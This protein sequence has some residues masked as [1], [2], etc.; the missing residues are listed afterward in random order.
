M[1]VCSQLNSRVEEFKK[2]IESSYSIN[3]TSS[4]TT[5]TKTTTTT[6]SIPGSP[7][8]SKNTC[9]YLKEFK[10]KIM[11]DIEKG[12]QEN[13]ALRTNNSKLKQKIECLRRSSSTSMNIQFIPIKD[14]ISRIKQQIQ[15]QKEHQTNIKTE[16]V[17]YQTMHLKMIEYIMPLTIDC[18]EVDHSVHHNHQLDYFINFMSLRIPL[19]SSPMSVSLESIKNIQTSESNVSACLGYSVLVLK[20]ISFILNLTLPY[21]LVYQG[22]T[23]YIIHQGRKYKLYIDKNNNQHNQQYDFDTSLKMLNKNIMFLCDK[24]NLE[25]PNGKQEASK[26][27]FYNLMW[28]IKSP[29]QYFSSVP[30]KVPALEQ[31]SSSPITTSPTT[32]DLVGEDIVFVNIPYI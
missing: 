2:K 8:N 3:T 9:T 15:Q 18:N 29:E 13:A 17:K 31:P 11:E 25:F 26:M 1:L 5:T 7:L 6:P 27:N 32:E 10:R 4:S 14:I 16:I 12:E 23:S 22:S 28:L 20:N 19:S 24:Y 30:L 21:E